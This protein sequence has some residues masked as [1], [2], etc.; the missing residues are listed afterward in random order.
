MHPGCAVSLRPQLGPFPCRGA[1]APVPQ[2]THP[3]GTGEIPPCSAFPFGLLDWATKLISTTAGQAL[4]SV[5]QAEFSC[6]MRETKAK[7]VSWHGMGSSIW[8]AGETSGN[9]PPSQSALHCVLLPKQMR[10]VGTDMKVAESDDSC[11]RLSVPPPNQ[12][13]ASAARLRSSGREKMLTKTYDQLHGL[14]QHNIHAPTLRARLPPPRAVTD[15]EA[16]EKMSSEALW[17]FKQLNLHLELEGRF[18]PREKGLSLIERAAEN[19]NTLCP[20]QRNAKVE[21]L[22][23]LT[24]FFG[25]S[26]E[27]FVLAVNILDRFLALMKVKPKHLSC[28]G[29]CCF[30]LAARVV[31]EECNIPSAQEIIRISQCKCT[32]SDLKRMEEIISE[33]LHFEFKATTALTFLHLYHTIVLC[34]TSERKEVLNLDKLE[35]QLKACNCRLVF[36]KAR[37]SVLA[38][39]LLTLEVETLKSV[40]LFEILLRVQKHSK[41]SDSDLLYWREL[42]SKCLADY[43]SPEC[44]KPDHTKLVWIVSRRTAQNLQNS[45]YSV[46]ELPTIPEGGCFN[47]S[48]SEDSCEDMSSAEDSLS[49]SPPSDLEGTF[50]FELEPKTKWQT[51]NCHS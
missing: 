37:P 47:E 27:T 8:A 46:P 41:I 4:A 17:L 51:L 13:S 29:V 44:C 35:A 33:K 1:A 25:F 34:H 19:E 38:L 9:Q 7:L 45:Y 15:P 14:I 31:E 20:R 32:V 36:S 12:A 10:C 3:R 40:E 22:W 48:E 6:S 50:F 39:C 30:Q 11:V 49:S 24:N 21:D 23:S 42:V 18:Q 28:I 26:T 43:S 5:S 16:R 2:R